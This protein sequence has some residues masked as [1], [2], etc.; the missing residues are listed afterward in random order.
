MTEKT[1][2]G[3]SNYETWAVSLWLDNERTSY[4]YWREQAE[5][6]RQK[7]PTC[8]QVL[9]GIWTAA[10]AT[11]FNLAD[12]LN[13]VE[14][15]VPLSEA[16]MYTDLLNASLAEVNWH[17]IAEHLLADTV[18]QE[19]DGFGPVIFSYSRAQAIAD[20]VLVDVTEMATEAGISVPTAVTA[21]VWERFVK[22]PDGVDGQ[23]ERG[24]LWDV[25]SMFYCAPG[26]APRA[27]RCCL[28]SWSGMTTPR[29]P[30][31]QSRVQPG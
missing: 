15:G 23:D 2:N 16:S 22:V 24:R 18:E 17:E 20:G 8:H 9:D 30:G 29:R 25:L 13:E 31:A 14:D 1:Y 11:K 26:E 12:Q 4:D 10:E 5:Q 21:A 19:D 28:T 6:H 27:T 3:W 7:A